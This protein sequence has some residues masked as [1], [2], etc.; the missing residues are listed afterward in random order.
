MAK[1]SGKKEGGGTGK[2]ASVLPWIIAGV[3]VVLVALALSGNLP[4]LGGGQETGKSFQLTGKE[5]KPVIDP[6]LFTGQTRLAYAAAQKY[7][8]ILNEVYCYCYC[9]APP[10]HHKTLLSCFTDRH[11]AG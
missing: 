5:T 6:A 10:F 8:D 11:G 2:K 9:D 1:K 3:A 7:P 4:F